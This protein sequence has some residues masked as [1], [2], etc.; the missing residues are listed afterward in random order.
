MCLGLLV[1]A[2]VSTSEKAMPFLVML[3]MFQVI[4]S[5]GVLPFNGMT[6][7][8]QLSWIAPARWG[9]AALASTVNLNGIGLL[10]GTDADPLWTTSSGRLAAGRRHHGRAG[11]SS[12][13]WSPWSSCAA[14][15]RAAAAELLHGQAGS[16]YIARKG[17]KKKKLPG[18]DGS[19]PAMY[20]C[21]RAAEGV[22]C[23]YSD[24]KIASA[25]ADA[26]LSA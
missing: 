4:L 13:C 19:G 1:S 14:S 5:G 2:F 12:T 21:H 24:P 25:A 9:F 7:L 22:R 15:A 16:C 17:K 3:T 11:Q 6:G 8:S 10:P 18:M 23:R 20:R 26:D